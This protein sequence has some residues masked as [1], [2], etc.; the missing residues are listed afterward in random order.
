MITGSLFDS[1]Y[2]AS[3]DKW[4]NSAFNGQ[5]MLSLLGGKEWK[6]GNMNTLALDLKFKAAGGRYYTPV[7]LGASQAAGV[8]IRDE[9]RAFES[10]LN[11]YLRADI[12]I[13]YRM[14]RNKVTH[15]FSLDLQNV[16]NRTNDFLPVYNRRTNSES[17]V[18]QI[19]FFP[20]PQYRIYF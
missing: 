5:Y 6:V 9:S 4:R 14:N 8:E 17:M 18:T 1:K 3:D 15:E 2:L 12:K 20:V 10:Q 13:S 19:G 11:D 16:T 7:D